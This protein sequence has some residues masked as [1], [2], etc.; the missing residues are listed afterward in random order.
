MQSTVNGWGGWIR[1]NDHGIKTQSTD[2]QNSAVFIASALQMQRLNHVNS[3]P[4]KSGSR[5]N[6]KEHS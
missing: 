5:L 4:M 1:T 6:T 3:Q 2:A